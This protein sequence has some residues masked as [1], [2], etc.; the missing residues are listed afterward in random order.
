MMII[1]S[2]EYIERLMEMLDLGKA[3][4]QHAEEQAALMSIRE[5]VALHGDDMALFA[6]A[7]YLR[8]RID[9]AEDFEGDDLDIEVE[10]FDKR[11]N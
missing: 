1:L 5:L 4:E 2:S 10:L 7:Y 9:Q 3:I 11:E 6:A 8:E